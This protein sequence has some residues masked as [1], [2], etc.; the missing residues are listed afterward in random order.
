VFLSHKPNISF[1]SWELAIINV[2]PLFAYGTVRPK[3]WA[4]SKKRAPWYDGFVPG[5]KPSPSGGAL[6]MKFKQIL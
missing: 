4:L 5:S 1:I 3:N 6:S 2:A